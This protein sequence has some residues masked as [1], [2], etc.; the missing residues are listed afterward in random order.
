MSMSEIEKMYQ[1]DEKQQAERAANGN[2]GTYLNELKIKAIGDS[3]VVQL[4]NVKGL[5]D[6]DGAYCHVTHPVSK[7]TNKKFTR[8]V[9]CL[10]QN[11]DAD[12]NCPL[13]NCDKEH[14]D[15]FN[16]KE[17]VTKEYQRQY[18]VPIILVDLNM[19][20][21]KDTG[22][23]THKKDRVEGQTV[24]AAPEVKF[25]RKGFKKLLI[26]R[27][28]EFIQ[29]NGDMTNKVLEIKAVSP[30]GE[31]KIGF[32]YEVT[33]VD[34]VKPIDI[35]T[36]KVPEDRFKGAQIVEETAEA[37]DRYVMTDSFSDDK[38]GGENTTTASDPVTPRDNVEP[39]PMPEEVA[40]EAL[41]DLPNVNTR[42]PE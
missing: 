29:K 8:Y 7:R 35:S 39:V 20:W 38:K 31:N 6:L 42:R 9:K 36:L 19:K 16:G 1:E 14:T 22:A 33:F 4:C 10:S 40:T 41:D 13:C 28:F 5:S 24:D 34:E 26:K 18:I 15:N 37:M 2:S 21:D 23:F 17:S 30:K 25:I 32:D 11:K 27:I 3:V 12:A